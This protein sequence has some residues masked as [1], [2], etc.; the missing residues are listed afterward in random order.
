MEELYKNPEER[1]RRG[2]LARAWVQ[3]RNCRIADKVD[4]LEQE[5]LQLTYGRNL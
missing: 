3:G 2:L 4:W 1:R 5:L